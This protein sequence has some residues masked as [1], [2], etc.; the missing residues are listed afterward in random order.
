MVESLG[1]LLILE[2]MSAF[3]VH[4]YSTFG[5]V[6]SKLDHGAKGG[7]TSLQTLTGRA[8]FVGDKEAISVSTRDFQNLK[9]NSIYFMENYIKV[10]SLEDEKLSMCDCNIGVYFQQL[11][12]FWMVP[13]PW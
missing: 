4:Y 10:Y 13:N 8:L 9:E 3:C 5:F 2:R 12:S 7:C 11:T 1:E 6:I